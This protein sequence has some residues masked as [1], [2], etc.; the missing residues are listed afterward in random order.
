M[1]N[2]KLCEHNPLH[3]AIIH[4]NFDEVEKHL[5]DEK[6]H[7]EGG[8]NPLHLAM[9]FSD[10]VNLFSEDGDI[11]DSFEAIKFTINHLSTDDEEEIR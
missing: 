5:D 4:K 3:L 1:L 9:D 10:C 7:D 2:I 6:I 11:I 8:R